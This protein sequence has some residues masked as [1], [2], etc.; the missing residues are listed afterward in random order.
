MGHG[1]G[2][3][4]EL[5]SND[6]GFMSYQPDV[7]SQRTLMARFQVNGT[8]PHVQ[9]VRKPVYTVLGLMA[10]LGEIGIYSFVSNGNHLGAM[11]TMHQLSPYSKQ[12]R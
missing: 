2:I 6:N 5:L 1:A 8:K 12:D 4:F 9:F 7:F 3:K 10:L 11:V